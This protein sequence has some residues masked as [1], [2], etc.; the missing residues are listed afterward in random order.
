MRGKNGF[1]D[2]QGMKQIGRGENWSLKWRG[3]G[4]LK[5]K[6]KK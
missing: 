4:K 3:N 5:K 6:K 2:N 1:G